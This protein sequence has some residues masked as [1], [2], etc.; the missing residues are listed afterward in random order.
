MKKRLSFVKLFLGFIGI[1]S[2]ISSYSQLVTDVSVSQIGKDVEVHYTLNSDTTCFVCLRLSEDNGA[3][4]GA[5]LLNIEGDVGVNVNVKNGKIV[6]HTLDQSFDFNSKKN[7]FTVVAFPY[8]KQFSQVFPIYPGGEVALMKL[9]YDNICYPEY[10]RSNHIEG[11][12][13]IKFIVE[14]DGTP[15][16]FQ[17][18]RGVEGGKGL[19]KEALAACE[20]IGRFYP[21]LRNGV[22]ERVYMMMPIKFN[23]SGRKKKKSK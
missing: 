7:Q 15:T 10:E 5:N 17:V 4:W 9:I 3:T 23:I 16:N 12:V 21:G 8:T 11:T 13:Y 2:F 22:P 1:L 19:D 20:K 6:W 18:S 14:K